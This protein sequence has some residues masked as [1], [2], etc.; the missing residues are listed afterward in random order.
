MQ[1]FGLTSLNEHKFIEEVRLKKLLCEPKEREK[2]MA[3]RQLDSSSTVFNDFTNIKYCILYWPQTKKLM[4]KIENLYKG[5]SVPVNFFWQGVMQFFRRGH[6]KYSTSIY[7]STL[8]ECRFHQCQVRYWMLSGFWPETRLLSGTLGCFSYPV[9]N[10][11]LRQPFLQKFY[12][13]WHHF[14]FLVI[15]KSLNLYDDSGKQTVSNSS[16]LLHSINFR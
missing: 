11:T 13:K 12:K 8:A 2:I 6:T 1:F 10:F 15:I 14:L 3:G 9:K 5:C 16:H 4:A 7:K